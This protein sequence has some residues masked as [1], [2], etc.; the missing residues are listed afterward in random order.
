MLSIRLRPQSIADMKLL[1]AKLR[2]VAKRRFSQSE[3]VELAIIWAENKSV[4]ELMD[5]Y[6]N[7]FRIRKKKN[8]Y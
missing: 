2:R 4:E 5:M 8:L 1:I 3:I 7:S 6:A